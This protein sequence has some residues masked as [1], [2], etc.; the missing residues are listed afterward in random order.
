MLLILIACRFCHLTFYV[1]R[2]CFR[3]HAYCGDFCRIEG[4]RQK[5]R[6]AQRRYRRTL[7]GKKN[8]R[9]AENRSRQKRS[10]KSNII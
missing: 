3:G 4:K 10:A 7:K 6:E 2:S 1:C 5:H 8:H 9:V